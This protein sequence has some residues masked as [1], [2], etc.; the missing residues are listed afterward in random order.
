ME[1]ISSSLRSPLAP[2]FNG[3]LHFS[4]LP[5]LQLPS[6]ARL[7]MGKRRMRAAPDLCLP[8]FRGKKPSLSK[9][10]YT[11]L[12]EDC[13]WPPV[14]P[15]PVPVA[16]GGKY[17]HLWSQHNCLKSWFPKGRNGGQISFISPPQMP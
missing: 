5:I 15:M 4:A 12:R 17:C 16:G 9:L 8:N 6:V 3:T 7:C 1:F 14:S 11:D 13:D 2:G 10:P